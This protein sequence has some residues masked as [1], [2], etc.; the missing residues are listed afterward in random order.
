MAVCV[1]AP[2][3]SHSVYVDGIKTSRP[4][5]NVAAGWALLRWVLDIEDPAPAAIYLGCENSQ[6]TAKTTNGSFLEVMSFDMENFF[7]ELCWALSVLHGQQ[8]PESSSHPG[9]RKSGQGRSCGRVGPA[10]AYST[11]GQ[12][13][14]LKAQG[15]EPMPE[16]EDDQGK[17]SYWLIESASVESPGVAHGMELS[18]CILGET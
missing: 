16:P 1:L 6:Q 4:E 13:V 10:L 2:S 15:W 8:A 3:L 12:Y 5:E 18:A 17:S 7:G 11:S 14:W 9:A